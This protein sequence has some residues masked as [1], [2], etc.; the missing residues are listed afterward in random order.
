M[1]RRKYNARDITE[2]LH[3]TT[4]DAEDEDDGGDVHHE[5]EVF[6]E[7]SDQDAIEKKIHPRIIIPEND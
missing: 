3:E 2:A 6:A 7:D 5:I 1:F 4:S